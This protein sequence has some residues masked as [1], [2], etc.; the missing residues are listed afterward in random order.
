[1]HNF[2]TFLFYFCT[3]AAI[4]YEILGLS[5]PKKMIAF[6]EMMV[7]KEKIV[8]KVKNNSTESAYI[9]LTMMYFMWLFIGLF[10]FQ[11]VIYLFIIMLSFL[12]KRHFTIVWADSLVTL[13]ILLFTIINAYHLH[14]SSMEIIK[15]VF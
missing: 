10:T 15:F 9:F 13:V 1:M 3:S 11:W 4:L 12:P 6:K 2:F 5:S 14:I 8:P 7:A